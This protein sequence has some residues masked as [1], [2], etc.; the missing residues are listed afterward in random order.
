MFACGGN[1]EPYLSAGVN[2]VPLAPL[3]DVSEATLP[4]V[5]ERVPADNAESSA[6]ALKLWTATYLLMGLCYS[7]ETV[8]QLLAGVQNMQESTTYQA[9]L[10]EGREAGREEGRGGTHRWGTAISR[11]FGNQAVRKA[12]RSDPSGN[13]GDSKSRATRGLGER[14]ITRESATGTAYSTAQ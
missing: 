10:R 8:S 6:R 4:G 5:V 14:I 13:R 11:S 3:T 12:R 9:I 1:P 7:E 2:L